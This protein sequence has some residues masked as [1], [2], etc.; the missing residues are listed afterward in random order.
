[1]ASGTFK[2]VYKGWLNAGGKKSPVAVMKIR[3]ASCATEVHVFLKLGK[4][5]RLVRFM[6]KC[7]EGESELLLT[8]LAPHGSLWDAFKKLE[9]KITMNHAIVMMLRASYLTVP[10]KSAIQSSSVII[11]SM[12]S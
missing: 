10:H 8:E 4:H 3:G 1:M 6:G 7:T 2:T 5:P 12:S 11:S 9:G